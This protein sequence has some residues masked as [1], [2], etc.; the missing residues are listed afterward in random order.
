MQASQISSIRL[1]QILPLLILIAGFVFSGPS[2]AD[3]TSAAAT[4]NVTA[5]QGDTAPDVQPENPVNTDDE[6]T[7]A[8]SQYQR[9]EYAKAAEIFLKPEAQQI[10]AVNY[11]L[12]NL[13]ALGLGLPQD[14]KK[15]HD[16][17][18]SAARLN[19]IPAMH[20]LGIVYARGLGV[21]KSYPIAA[22]WYLEAVKQDYAPAMHNLGN[23]YAVG[24]GVK[25]DY[26]K[27][28]E[29]YEAA[30]ASGDAGSMC[31]LGNLYRYG[32]GVPMNFS[33]AKKWYEKGAEKNDE[34]C[35]LN[36]AWFYFRGWGTPQDLK[37]A[38]ELDK[39]GA[40]QGSPV[41]AF[42]LA[43]MYHYGMGTDED[44]KAAWYWYNQSAAGNYAPAMEQIADIFEQGLLGQE[45]SA[46]K[47]AEWKNMAKDAARETAKQHDPFSS[48]AY[49]L[50]DNMPVLPPEDNS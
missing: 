32:Y 43:R 14:D 38:S 31:N 12:G 11:Y 48:G 13:Y 8:I 28:R 1:T 26:E 39:T 18:V 42:N 49:G 29:L 10:P 24:L 35:L 17:Y 45:A 33:T 25:Q 20:S 6:I 3:D 36:L 9:G 50:E 15:A 21:R 19:H 34:C 44:E 4:D 22:E 2:R 40:L 27:A 37:K 5:Q 46:E 7:L 41:A 30:A 23:L 16:H 47:A